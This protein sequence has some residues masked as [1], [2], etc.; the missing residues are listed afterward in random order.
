MKNEIKLFP[1]ER[2]ILEIICQDSKT[3]IEIE[4]EVGLSAKIVNTILLKMKGKG[5][6]KK[7]INK[8][9]I[10]NIF[11]ENLKSLSASEIKGE[12]KELIE[13][14]LDN[15]FEK[16]NNTDILKLKKISMDKIDHRSLEQHFQNLETFI[17]YLEEKQSNNKILKSMGER[18]VIYWGS[19]NYLESIHKTV[20]K[21]I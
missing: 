12:I 19:S 14:S 6:L 17:K 9:Q 1:I 11:L 16:R 5:Y 20:Q 7:E 18:M 10:D 3:T 15:Y 8:W 13:G 21:L 2:F 4:R